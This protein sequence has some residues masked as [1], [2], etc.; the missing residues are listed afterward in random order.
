MWCQFTQVHTGVSSVQ[1]PRQMT[2]NLTWTDAISSSSR[3]PCT[4]AVS[5]LV[6]DPTAIQ[7]WGGA[8][9]LSGKLCK[10]P[11]SPH[12]NSKDSAGLP[13]LVSIN[14]AITHSNL[15]A[16]CFSPKSSPW[17]LN[18]TWSSGSLVH[19]VPK[20]RSLLFMSCDMHI[21]ASGNM[22]RRNENDNFRKYHKLKI[23]Y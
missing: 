6:M 12:T 18:G 15:A 17:P 10:C 2:L 22:K 5:Y 7:S 16:R 1:Y 13:F 21:M 19:N 14:S 11:I 20:T 8:I 4:G 23:C 3:F 9:S